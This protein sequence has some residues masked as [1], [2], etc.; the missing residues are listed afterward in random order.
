M[1]VLG[2][3]VDERGSLFLVAST[4]TSNPRRRVE[5]EAIPK[6]LGVDLGESVANVHFLPL[7]AQ[8]V[9]AP[10]KTRIL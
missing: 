10:R 1:Q 4:I 8:R 7:I 3:P 2:A 6:N 9:I 5:F